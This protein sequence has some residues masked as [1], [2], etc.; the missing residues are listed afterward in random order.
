MMG[1]ENPAKGAGTDTAGAKAG[2]TRKVVMDMDPG[3]QRTGVASPEAVVELAQQ[4]VKLKALVYAGVQ[5]YCG[6]HQHIVDF[7]QLKV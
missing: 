6:R 2:K 4:I 3:M 7:K 5:F 1:A